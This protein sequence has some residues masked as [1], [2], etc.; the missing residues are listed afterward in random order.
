MNKAWV[1]PSVMCMSEW[2]GAGKKLDEL[3]SEYAEQGRL[4]RKLG[5]ALGLGTAV[6][7]M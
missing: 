2:R 6:M 7:L 4:Y 5:V 1:S 3:R